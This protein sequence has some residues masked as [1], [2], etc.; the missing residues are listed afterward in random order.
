M[1][2]SVVALVGAPK[3]QKQRIVIAGIASSAVVIVRGAVV[4]VVG[5]ELQPDAQ[6]LHRRPKPLGCES[7]N[8]RI[9]GYISVYPCR[10]VQRRVGAA[11]LIEEPQAGAIT[12]QI[13][14]G[15]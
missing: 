5:R 10:V 3:V 2:A 4:F 12:R 9:A 8:S 6:I 13:D 14:V 11:G 7:A 1:L 15:R